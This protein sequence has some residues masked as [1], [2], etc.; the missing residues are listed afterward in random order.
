MRKVL[1]ILMLCFAGAGYAEES[2]IGKKVDHAGAAIKEGAQDTVK[3]TKELARDVKDK[4]CHLVKGKMECAAEKV[5]H[6]IQNGAD[7]ISD[8]ANDV[9]KH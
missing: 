8:K 5:K 7:E 1:F 2:S 6:K 4:T 3:N 9:K